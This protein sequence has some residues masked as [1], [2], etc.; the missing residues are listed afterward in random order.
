MQINTFFKIPLWTDTGNR[1]EFTAGIKLRIPFSRGAARFPAYAYKSALVIKAFYTKLELKY[2]DPAL[3]QG[4]VE[5][6]QTGA[7]IGFN[8]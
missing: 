5:I 2:A 8:F 3:L 1:K 6:E 7:S 4:T